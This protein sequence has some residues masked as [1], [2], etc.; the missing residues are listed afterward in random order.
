MDY[1]TIYLAISAVCLGRI[2]IDAA[3]EVTEIPVLK[4][5]QKNI[6]AILLAVFSP[7]LAAA[8]TIKD[9]FK[10]G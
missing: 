7:I 3:Q 8:L 5:I 4:P 6:T 9:L 10:K 1:L 2:F